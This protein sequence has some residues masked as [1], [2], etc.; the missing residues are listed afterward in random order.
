MDGKVLTLRS[1]GTNAAGTPFH[2][3]MVFDK[4]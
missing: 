2:N 4:Q 1:K 3:V